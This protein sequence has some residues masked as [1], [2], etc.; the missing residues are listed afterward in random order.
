MSTSRKLAL[1]IGVLIVALIAVVVYMNVP[2]SSGD[3]EDMNEVG[4]FEGSNE[5]V[6]YEL[7][8]SE[9][10][11]REWRN[12]VDH[13]RHRTRQVG[14]ARSAPGC[15]AILTTDT[16]V[17]KHGNYLFSIQVKASW[18]WRNGS[19]SMTEFDRDYNIGDEWWNLY[20]FRGWKEPVGAVRPRYAYHRQGAFFEACWTLCFLDHD[21]W[22]SQTVRRDGSYTVD[23]KGRT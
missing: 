13:W 15:K 5:E 9:I 17:S 21:V 3:L 14:L 22:V 12:H 2:A 20:R 16:A 23:Y 6:P 4:H 11:R 10:P 7:T 8:S 18:C 19:I 1:G